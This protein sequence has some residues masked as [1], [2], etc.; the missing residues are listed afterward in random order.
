[1]RG[2]E[3]QIETCFASQFLWDGLVE[4]YGNLHS[5]AFGCDHD[6]AV[7]IIV[8]VAQSHLDGTFLTIHLSAGHR[9]HEIP[10]LRGVVQT[11][12]TSLDSAHTVMDN[13]N[14]RILLVVETA[15]EAVAIDEYVHTLALE[16]LEVIKFQVLCPA[17]GCGQHCQ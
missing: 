6:A 4:P 16:V 13:L 8:I 5:L 15:V 12:G 2:Q 1:M 17:N 3:L 7:K 14:T 9:W 11:D 10:L